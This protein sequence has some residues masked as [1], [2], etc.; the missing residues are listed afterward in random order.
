M[1]KKRKKGGQPGN[2]NALK[3][4]FYAQAM[5]KQ[6]MRDLVKVG[7]GLVDEINLMRT[8]IRRVAILAK[9]E[10]DQAELTNLLDTL[11]AAGVRLGSMLRTQRIYFEGKEGEELTRNLNEAVNLVWEE[12][13]GSNVDR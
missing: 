3:H 2:L 6:E 5:D 8:I 9:D 11:G 13:N 12:I 7:L 4:G 1:E 10:R